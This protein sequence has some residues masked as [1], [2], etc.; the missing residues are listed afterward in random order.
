[1]LLAREHIDT[2]PCNGSEYLLFGFLQPSVH[3]LA[4]DIIILFEFVGAG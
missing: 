4:L 2:R 1:M 3:G